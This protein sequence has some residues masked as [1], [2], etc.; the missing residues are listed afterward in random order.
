MSD[1]NGKAS[2]ELLPAKRSYRPMRLD[3]AEA[4]APAPTGLGLWAE[5]L[6]AAAYNAVTEVDVEAMIAAQVEKAKAGDAAAAKFVI[7]F[8]AAPAP[9]VQVQKVVIRGR[10]KKR[11]ADP[12]AVA[13]PTAPPVR[14][15][16]PNPTPALKVYR[17]LAAHFIHVGGPATVAAIAQ[18]LELPHDQVRAVIDCTWFQEAHG[19]IELTPMGRQVVA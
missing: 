15:A 9:K 1:L 8:L 12:D 13:S 5:K 7:G 10:G 16:E 6:R 4:A 14:R 18:Q 11:P 17:R 2:G 19:A 3:D